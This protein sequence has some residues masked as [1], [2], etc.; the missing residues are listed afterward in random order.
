MKSESD[1]VT[2]KRCKRGAELP[3]EKQIIK[4]GARISISLFELYSLSSQAFVGLSEF[5]QLMGYAVFPCCSSLVYQHV[6]SNGIALLFS[7]KSNF[8]QQA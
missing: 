7:K 3:W 5:T 1:V 8:H 4:E 6:H 2:G